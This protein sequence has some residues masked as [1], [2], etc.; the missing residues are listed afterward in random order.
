MNKL[1]LS[2]VMIATWALISATLYA[3][4][5]K[6]T[7]EVS[8]VARSQVKTNHLSFK[9]ELA[10]AL[11]DSEVST[12]SLPRF[13][14]VWFRDQNRRQFTIDLLE[15]KIPLGEEVEVRTQRGLGFTAGGEV[16]DGSAEFPLPLGVEAIL[17][18][19]EGK[20]D[21]FDVN[22]RVSKRNRDDRTEV[23]KQSEMEGK[24]IR[25]AGVRSFWIDSK[26]TL[27]PN[28]PEVV[29][30]MIS[31]TKKNGQVETEETVVVIRV[32]PHFNG[33]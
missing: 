11:H 24:S 19:Q 17:R 20:N 27:Q 29:G 18:C 1:M 25:V 33:K 22:F 2:W 5:P 4:S 12:E 32:I 30:G 6:V 13:F 9:E 15:A 31:E 8:I 23:W 21:Q 10:T 14:E 26:L 7:I 28:M 3:E 16:A